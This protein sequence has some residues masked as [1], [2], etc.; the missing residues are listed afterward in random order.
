VRVL[1]I[2][3]KIARLLA[4]L[5]A[6]GVGFLW[7]RRRA[8]RV[9]RDSLRQAGLPRD[10][11]ESLTHDYRQMMSLPGLRSLSKWKN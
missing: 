7:E 8:V 2:G 6:V 10:V 5:T 4:G 11:I 1:R 9:F 3:G